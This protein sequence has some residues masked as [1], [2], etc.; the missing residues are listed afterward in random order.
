MTLSMHNFFLKLNF[1][2]KLLFRFSKSWNLLPC[3]LCESGDGS[4]ENLICKECLKKLNFI[5]ENHCRG[6]GGINDGVLAVCRKCLLEEMRPWVN[7]IAV[8]DY[9]GL[10]KRT[11]SSFKFFN[12]PELAR[13]LADLAAPLVVAT[14]EPCDLLIPVPLHY[15]RE[16]QRSYNQSYFLA[17]ECGKRLN[18]PVLRAIKR[19]RR[20]PRQA[21]LKRE[22]RHKNLNSA[23]RVTKPK[24]IAN[25][26][27]WLIDD[28]LTTGAT[29]HTVAQ[30][31]QKYNPKSIRILVI[32]RA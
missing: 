4:G 26:N 8:F 28:V 22:A 14:Q 21:G 18:V 31:I 3:P 13:P 29:L 20:T 1:I 32:A 5:K 24:E 15:T 11:I 16:F 10:G 6:C 19:V 25:K 9:Q 17:T 7:A 12:N 23:F 2:K 27:I 30:T